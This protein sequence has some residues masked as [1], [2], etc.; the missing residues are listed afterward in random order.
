MVILHKKSASKLCKLRAGQNAARRGHWTPGSVRPKCKDAPT[1]NGED[2][3][4]ESER[5]KE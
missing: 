1:K 3:S 4:A 5:E 2:I